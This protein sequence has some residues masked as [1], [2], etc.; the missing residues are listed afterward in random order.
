M[1]RLAPRAVGLDGLGA[2]RLCVGRL[3]L[4]QEHQR[5]VAEDEVPLRRVVR[6]EEVEAARVVP[7]GARQVLGL[8]AVVA[9]LLLLARGGHLEDALLG[10]ALEPPR[11]GLVALLRVGDVGEAAPVAAR[12]RLGLLLLLHCLPRLLERRCCGLLLGDLRLG[13]GERGEQLGGVDASRNDEAAVVAAVVLL[14]VALDRGVGAA[15]QLLHLAAG[16]RVVAAQRIGVQLVEAGAVDQ[17]L[18]RVLAPL[19]LA[20]DHA[21]VVALLGDVV[22]LGDERLVRERWEEHVVHV[23]RQ[24]VEEAFRAGRGDRV[25]CVVNVGPRVR[26]L[27]QAPVRQLVQHALEGVQ[28]RAQEHEVLERVWQPVVAVGVLVGRGLRREHGVARHQRPLARQQAH[29]QPAGVRLEHPHGDREPVKALQLGP[30]G[31]DGRHCL[32]VAGET[33]TRGRVG[34]GEW[35]HRPHLRLL[36]AMY[37]FL[38]CPRRVHPK[39]PLL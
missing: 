1:P 4:L 31:G 34:V 17:A 30:A 12:R 20:V 5:P 28:L 24:Q 22:D 39:L 14:V 10:G 8:E 23:N 25:R 26:A 33:A 37:T 32:H 19:H 36:L 6:G 15:A 11:L 18:T 7:H 29:A 2:V 13:G 3:V 27:R 9:Q 16:L 21:F 38:R 35:G